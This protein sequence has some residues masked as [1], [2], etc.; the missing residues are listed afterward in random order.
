MIKLFW[1]TIFYMGLLSCRSS[2]WLLL[3]G[4]GFALMTVKTNFAKCFMRWTWAFS[5]ASKTFVAEGYTRHEHMFQLA[6]V[7]EQ[8]QVTSYFFKLPGA[9]QCM[10]QAT[11]SA[12]VVG[13]VNADLLYTV[14]N[15]VMST[16]AEFAV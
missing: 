16:I 15:E 14:L 11:M 1:H 10:I 7:A 12:E 3:F 9:V 5:V 4:A 6:S 8:K 13:Q 2:Y